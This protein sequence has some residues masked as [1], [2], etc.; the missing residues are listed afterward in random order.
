[1]VK[2]L[3]TSKFHAHVKVQSTQGTNVKAAVFQIP[4]TFLAIMS[5]ISPLDYP[6]TGL[7]TQAQTKQSGDD[8]F[9][10]FC[11]SIRATHE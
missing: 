3:I 11:T 9:H 2:F 8:A 6:R 1:M 10:T 7:P 4:R 5:C